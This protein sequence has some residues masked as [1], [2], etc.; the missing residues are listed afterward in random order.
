MTWN[1]QGGHGLDVGFVGARVLSEHADVVLI[2]EIQ[3]RQARR[4]ATIVGMHHRWARKHLP[5]PRFSEGMAIFA[6][7]PIGRFTAEVITPAAW[8]SWRRRIVLRAT[9]AHSS[10]ASTL[11]VF[12]VHLSPHNATGR[13]A[14]ELAELA[15]LDSND[16][17]DVIAGDFNAEIA[18]A[19]P[20]LV[21]HRDIT[22]NGLPTCWGPGPRI[23]RRPTQRLDGVFAAHH[24]TAHDSRTPSTE[25]DQWARASDHLPVAVTLRSDGSAE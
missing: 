12:N 6:K 16:P 23:G 20:S 3:R 17:A 10:S 14:I 2:Q 24:W 1:V 22:A 25:L 15:R 18:I 4:L 21:R 7:A 8:W 9:I 19:S 11:R 5:F 13:R